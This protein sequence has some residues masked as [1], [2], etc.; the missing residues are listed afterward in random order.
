MGTTQ[1]Q[2]QATQSKEKINS[3]QWI[4]QLSSLKVFLSTKIHHK[5]ILS[6][7][8]CTKFAS[9]KFFASIFSETVDEFENGIEH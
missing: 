6:F 2:Q 8:V 7:L 9:S 1:T 5:I 3:P 4:P